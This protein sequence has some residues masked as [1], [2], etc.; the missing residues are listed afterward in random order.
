VLTYY[1]LR[2][3]HARIT[4]LVRYYFA[5][6]WFHVPAYLAL[7]LWLALQIG[8]SLLQTHAAGDVSGLAHL[9]GASVGIAAWALRRT[10]GVQPST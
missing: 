4:F 7:G 2:F 6:R 10:L 5:V 1:A 8:I 3:P 9:G